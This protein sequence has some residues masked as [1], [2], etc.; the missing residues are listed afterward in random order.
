MDLNV[1]IG[2]GVSFAA[3]VAIVFFNR[4]NIKAFFE[5]IE[6]KK[7]W[8]L[9]RHQFVQNMNEAINPFTGYQMISYAINGRRNEKASM[10]YNI[11]LVDLNCKNK[12]KAFI[13]NELNLFIDTLKSHEFKT[14]EISDCNGNK[15]SIRL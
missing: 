5:S 9:K 4:K 12:W 15:R 8:A 14:L 1:M 13:N 7:E 3:I 2:S 11:P 6:R 10:T